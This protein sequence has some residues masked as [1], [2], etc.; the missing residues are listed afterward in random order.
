MEKSYLTC[1]FISTIDFCKRKKSQSLPHFFVLFCFDNW[2]YDAKNA[3]SEDP[4][5][6]LKDLKS[7]FRPPIFACS[8]WMDAKTKKAVSFFLL[9]LLDWILTWVLIGSEET[10][11]SHVWQC[12]TIFDPF[13]RSFAIFWK[14]PKNPKILGFFKKILGYPKS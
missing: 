2:N 5:V 12:Q 9:K 11:R 6:Y 14:I 7:N 10:I 1:Y 3:I 8:T 4:F 13:S